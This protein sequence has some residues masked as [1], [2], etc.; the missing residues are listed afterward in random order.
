MCQAYYYRTLRQLSE[1]LI[2]TRF[3]AFPNPESRAPCFSHS[4]FPTPQVYHDGE[5]RRGRCQHQTYSGS[6]WMLDHESHG[7]MNGNVPTVPGFLSRGAK[8]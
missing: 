3:R 5:G 7:R 4:L 8:A 1:L 6:S 2:F